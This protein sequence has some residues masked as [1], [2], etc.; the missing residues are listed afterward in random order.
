MFK[1]FTV[2]DAIKIG[3]P[4]MYFLVLCSIL[5]VAVILERLYYYYQ[6][7]RISREAF[8]KLIR[9]ELANGNIE[10]ALAIA[11]DSQTPFA[12]VVG[13]GINTFSS[14]EKELSQALERRI[15]IEANELERRT[16]IVGTI[17]S[18]AV[19]IGL[20]GTVGGIIKTFQ[21]LAQAGSGGIDIVIGGV[22]EALVCTAAGLFV[23]IPAVMAF[24]YFMKRVQ[25]FVLDMELCASEI[26][27]ILTQRK[28]PKRHEANL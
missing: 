17:G 9:E 7:S 18:T 19:Y 16:A 15:L 10:K 27:S 25:R 2:W 13:E 14:D 8:M 28:K 12:S 3:G 24:N 26:T 4:V 23:A 11:R 5:S 6:R 1:S 22:A 20:L 21:D